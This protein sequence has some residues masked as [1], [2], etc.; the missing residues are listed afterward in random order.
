MVLVAVR[1]EGSAGAGAAPV[2][3]RVVHVDAVAAPLLLG[4]CQG[5]NREM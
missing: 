3:I 5:K 1:R 4:S 2:E